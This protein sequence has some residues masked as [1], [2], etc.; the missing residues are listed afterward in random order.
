M[1]NRGKVVYYEPQNVHI[2]DII[3]ASSTKYL[4][5]VL[6]VTMNERDSI[7]RIRNNPDNYGNK[8]QQL[9]GIADNNKESE[10]NATYNAIQPLTP[11]YAS[12]INSII[13]YTNEMAK[14]CGGAAAI[15]SPVACKYPAPATI[16]QSLTSPGSLLAL[17]EKTGL[18]ATDVTGAQIGLIPITTTPTRV[19][20]ANNVPQNFDNG[21]AKYST[22]YN[23]T[24]YYV[25]FTEQTPIIKPATLCGNPSLECPN[26]S[27]LYG[28]KNQAVGADPGYVYLCNNTTRQEITY[29]SGGAVA[30]PINNVNVGDIIYAST[31]TAIS[32][33]LRLISQAL[34]TYKSWWDPNGG[35]ALSCQTSCQ[36]ACM[37]SC[38]NCYGGTCHNQNCGGFS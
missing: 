32:T 17:D 20:D 11:V 26:R 27:R 35:C 24:T 28:Y 2:G 33:N 7:N 34:D 14:T 30:A 12:Y 21:S 10:M 18:P 37:L 16:E 29:T 23:N 3:R 1:A 13:K 4:L 15:L 19:V 6:L 38:Q 9:S 22:L 31:F 36:R 25:T 8:L 5:S